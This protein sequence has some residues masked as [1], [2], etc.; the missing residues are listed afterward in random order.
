MREIGAWAGA[1]AVLV[2][3]LCLPLVLTTGAR[4]E[5]GG[6]RSPPS[7]TLA[8]FEELYQRIA[9]T[10]EDA[11]A[12]ASAAA[13]EIRFGLET[14]L[15]R[16]DAEIEVLKLEA[17]RFTGE[18]QRQALDRLVA[19]AAARERRLWRAIRRLEALTGESAVAPAAPTR[20]APD[21]G[22]AT[23]QDEAT[24]A[25]DGGKP[26]SIQMVFEKQDVTEDPDP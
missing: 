7:S 14:D 15:I 10:A 20:E 3:A 2:A 22:A 9:K 26:S 21:V 4:A 17:A 5:E 25:E 12:A 18:R 19:A 24:A 23:G 8:A 6:S 1:R 13:D 16:A 11:N